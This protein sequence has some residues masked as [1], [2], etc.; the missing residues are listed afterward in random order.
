MPKAPKILRAAK[1]TTSRHGW[2]GEIS[3]WI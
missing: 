3:S 1:K 2:R